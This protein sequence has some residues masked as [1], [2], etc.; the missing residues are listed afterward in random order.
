MQVNWIVPDLSIASCNHSNYFRI[1]RN[2]HYHFVYRIASTISNHRSGRRSIR[3]KSHPSLNW[4]IIAWRS[5]KT[6]LWVTCEFMLHIRRSGKRYSPSA[7]PGNTIWHKMNVNTPFLGGQIYRIT[8]I[9]LIW[10]IGI[11]IITVNMKNRAIK[12]LAQS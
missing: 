10:E 6:P 8:S 4:Y 2:H 1:C 3:L 5:E 12:R 7:R 9:R 11:T